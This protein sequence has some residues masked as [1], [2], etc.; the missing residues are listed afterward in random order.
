MVN[1]KRLRCF[2][3]WLAI[4]LPWLLALILK[5]IPPSISY[6]YYTHA[7]TVFTIIL[8]SAS[9][10]LMYYDG[11]EK[12]DD[13]IN[14]IASFFGFAICLFPC[15]VQA[16]KVGVFQI[17][18]EISAVIHNVCAV[19]FFA[20]LAY[21]SFFQFTKNNGTMSRNKCIRNAIYRIC[22]IGMIGAF[23]LFAL[24]HFYCKIWLIETIA[25]FFFGVSWLTKANAYKWLFAEK[26]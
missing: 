22:G 16:D 17:K 8:G 3:G 10:L 20:I 14:T 26:D 25:L 6:T 24:P 9:V 7:G 23:A 18:M 19:I 2:I 4:L 13:I 15:E 1:V 21:N 11:Y 5:E 12:A